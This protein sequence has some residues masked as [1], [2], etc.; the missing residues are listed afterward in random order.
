M[1]H[2]LR[3]LHNDSIVK[4]AYKGMKSKHKGIR[5]RVELI[6]QAAMDRLIG[7]QG[8]AASEIADW[9][10]LRDDTGNP[11]F[12]IQQKQVDPWL[13]NALSLQYPCVQN[14]FRMEKV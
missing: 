14:D 4:M 8:M 1:Y 2:A 7:I 11:L 5:D 12:T 3:K 13:Y 9:P 6:N 10:L